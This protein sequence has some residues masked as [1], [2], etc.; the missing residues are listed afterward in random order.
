[1]VEST[2]E[3]PFPGWNEGINTSAPLIYIIRQGGLQI[4]GSENYLDVIPCDMVAAGLTLALGELLEGR[5]KTV[6]QLGSSD[7]NP[8]TM[9][10]FFELTGLY[11]R[12]S[13]KRT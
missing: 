6:Y 5:H 7:S 13:Y 1:V 8:C 3:Y 11:K 10:R 4:P 9:R 2:N 12:K